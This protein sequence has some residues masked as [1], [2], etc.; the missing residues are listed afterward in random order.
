MKYDIIG[1]CSIR[2]NAAAPTRPVFNPLQRP[3]A[4]AASLQ[5]FLVSAAL[6]LLSLSRS[7]PH[8]DVPI[9]VP[10]AVAPVPLRVGRNV[11]NTTIVLE[12]VWDSGVTVATDEARDEGGAPQHIGHQADVHWQAGQAWVAGRVIEHGH[13]CLLHD[14]VWGQVDGLERAVIHQGVLLV[15]TAVHRRLASEA[16]R[17][18]LHPAG[19][20][21]Q[22]L[23]PPES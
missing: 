8:P 10:A 21:L 1:Q 11:S 22:Q 15:R 18:H 9:V 23:Q 5:H 3:A 17:T 12:A 13:T 14:T 19:E 4:A 20:G 16:C 2:S 7:A 6:I